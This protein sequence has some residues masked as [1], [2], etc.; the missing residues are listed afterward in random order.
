MITVVGELAVV[1]AIEKRLHDA[2]GKHPIFT[3]G[4]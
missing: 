2:E 4:C 3:I 1:L